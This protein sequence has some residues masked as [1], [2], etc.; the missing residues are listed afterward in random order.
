MCATCALLAMTAANGAQRAL[1]LVPPRWRKRGAAVLLAAGLAGASVGFSGS[2][3]P[4]H[5]HAPVATVSP[6]HTSLIGRS[7][8]SAVATIAVR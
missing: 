3:R 8:T 6:A 1:D 7:P 5:P 4:S 2:D